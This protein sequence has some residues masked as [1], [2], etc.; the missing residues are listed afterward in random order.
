LYIHCLKYFQKVKSG[1]L[2]LIPAL[3]CGRVQHITKGG[4]ISITTLIKEKTQQKVEM[5]NDEYEDKRREIDLFFDDLKSR[6]E[7]RR[8]ELQSELFEVCEKERER[9]TTLTYGEGESKS[10]NENERELLRLRETCESLLDEMKRELELENEN[11]NP[12]TQTQTSPSSSLTSRSRRKRTL[13]K[14][15]NF[16]SQITTSSYFEDDIASPFLPPSG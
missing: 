16:Q 4:I 6:C 1:C 2:L 12:E 3:F 5:L 9:L 15:H 11:E 10:E 13:D 7:R 14:Y 8:M